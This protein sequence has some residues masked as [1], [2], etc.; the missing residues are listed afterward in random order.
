MNVLLIPVG[1]WLV[2][3]LLAALLAHR[4][5]HAVTKELVARGPWG[6]WMALRALAEPPAPPAPM[7][8]QAPPPPVPM[9]VQAP[10]PMAVQ[11]PPPVVL[12]EYDSQE[13]PALAALLASEKPQLLTPT[14]L[15]AAEPEPLVP[16]AP[17][18]VVAEVQTAQ[19]V[20]LFQLAEQRQQRPPLPATPAVSMV[21]SKQEVEAFDQLPSRPRAGFARAIC[22]VCRTRTRHDRDAQCRKCKQLNR[23]LAERWQV[24][25]YPAAGELSAL[26]PVA[27]H[28]P[29]T[30]SGQVRCPSCERRYVPDLHGRCVFCD[31]QSGGSR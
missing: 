21:D 6:V 7:A 8:V 9:P 11:A 29:S 18:P 25:E 1:W 13:N 16:L 24:D 4:S 5:G 26:G 15:P 20:N 27:P 12:D 19:P 28:E 17:E 30:L 23:R 22:P 10:T 3:G 14:V 31:Y 2:S